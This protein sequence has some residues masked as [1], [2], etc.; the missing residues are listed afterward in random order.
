MLL[1]HSLQALE[2]SPAGRLRLGVLLNPARPSAGAGL[3]LALPIVHGAIGEGDPP[4]VQQLRVLCGLQQSSGSHQ[5]CSLGLEGAD[6]SGC[7]M[8]LQYG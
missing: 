5:S 1:A 8:I 7:S 2:A 4:R 6:G 3:L